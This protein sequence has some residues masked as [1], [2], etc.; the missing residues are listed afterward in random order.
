LKRLSAIVLWALVLAPWENRS[1]ARGAQDL[2]LAPR[3]AYSTMLGC[4]DV[5][6]HAMNDGRTEIL[7]IEA[8]FS[9]V[10]GP[11]PQQVFDLARLPPGVVVEVALYK[12]R[13]V[14]RPNCD[15]VVLIEAGKVPERPAVWR[16]IRGTLEVERGPK[17]VRSEEPWLFRATLRLVGAAF[18]GPSGRVVEIGRP[19]TWEA[20]VGWQAG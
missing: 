19:F 6:F 18:Q 15:D 1:V 2:E 11:S 4:G 12:G 13:Q 14:N 7:R 10:R 9:R 3:F 20:F 8:D 5:F 16:P 17:G